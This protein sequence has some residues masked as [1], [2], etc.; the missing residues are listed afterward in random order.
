LL[1]NLSY[2]EKPKEILERSV[3]VFWNK[4]I[5]MVKIL[6]GHHG[7]QDATWET[8]EWMRNKCPEI[9]RVK[10]MSNFE[11]KILLSWGIVTTRLI[12]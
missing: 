4:K 2:V 10:T 6:W 9:F 5:P 11:N 3:K 12:A 7:I 1:P 8:K